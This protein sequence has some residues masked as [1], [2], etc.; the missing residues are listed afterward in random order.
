MNS[1]DVTV[2]GCTVDTGDDNC[3]VKEVSLLMP[4]SLPRLF[5]RL[6]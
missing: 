1:S 2:R 5:K 3:A 6:G 4:P